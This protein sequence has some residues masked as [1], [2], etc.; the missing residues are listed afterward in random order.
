MPEEK[1]LMISLEEEKARSL[2]KI[3]ASRTSRKILDH[4][5]TREESSES[6]VANALKIP[7]S[8]VH[9]N[10]QHLKKSGLVEVKEF[11]WSKK[12]REI[13]LYKIAKKHIIISPK[14]TSPTKE[15]LQRILPIV[16]F[17]GA[18]SVA[19]HIYNRSKL[20][21]GV[22]KTS[23]FSRA[24]EAIN[25]AAKEAGKSELLVQ[26]VM[27]STEAVSKSIEAVNYTLTENVFNVTIQ[28]EPNYALWF[29]LG[30]L[31]SLA[32]YFLITMLRKK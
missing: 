9:Y 32:L 17:S 4:L 8:T 25:F 11:R 7:L 13:D 12:G 16:L 18:V 27:D 15:I 19:I 2:A 30:S 28:Q 26:K 5:S 14:G 1:F 31:T 22:V 10:L 21:L 24:D 29:F 23:T 6:E 20:G 3:L